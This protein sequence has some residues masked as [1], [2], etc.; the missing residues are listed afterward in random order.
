MPNCSVHTS[1][2][3]SWGW[4]TDGR[5]A[6]RAFV[7]SA[8]LRG[9]TASGAT[10]A[11]AAGESSRISSNAASLHTSLM[12]LALYPSHQD[13]NRARTHAHTHTRGCQMEA[14]VAQHGGAASIGLD[15]RKSRVEWNA[16]HLPAHPPTRFGLWRSK[17]RPRPPSHP[18]H[19]SHVLP[20]A[21]PGRRR[22]RA[23]RES[24]GGLGERTTHAGVSA[25]DDIG[26]LAWLAGRLGRSLL[27]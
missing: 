5:I 22:P 17:R 26:C 9:R 16:T 10:V 15:S 19:S 24:R 4:L 20:F 6:P 23:R 8:L 1:R 14:H 27:P 12:S 3:L 18:S 11:R 25:C 7:K 2:L 13:P 21:S